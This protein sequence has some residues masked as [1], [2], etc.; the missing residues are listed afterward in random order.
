MTTT[1]LFTLVFAFISLAAFTGI[2]LRKAEMTQ[3][4]FDNISIGK[5]DF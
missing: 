2:L 1:L 4:G 5:G 3:D